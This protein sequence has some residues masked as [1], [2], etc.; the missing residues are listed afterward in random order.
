MVCYLRYDCCIILSGEAVKNHDALEHMM[1]DAKAEYEQ[2]LKERLDKRRQ[3][4][5]QGIQLYTVGGNGQITY[6]FS[7]CAS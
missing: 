5:Q 1:G 6:I 4:R 7:V 2:K 3:R